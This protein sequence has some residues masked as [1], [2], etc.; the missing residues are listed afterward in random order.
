MAT[1]EAVSHLPNGYIYYGKS[2]SESAPHTDWDWLDLL[3]NGQR[4][5][6]KNNGLNA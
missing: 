3:N 1:H 4:V 6:T 2:D 5:T